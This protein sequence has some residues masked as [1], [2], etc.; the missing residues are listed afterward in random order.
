VARTRAQ[1]RRRTLLITLALVVTLIVL[2]FARDVSRAAHGAITARRSE[3]RSFGALANAL[4]LEENSF[5]GRL[6]RLLSQGGTL[7]REV[8][9]ARLNQLDEQLPNWIT[10]SDQLRRPVLS[11]NVNDELNLL[12]QE[13]VAAYQVLLGQ[14]A[15]ELEL[16]WTPSTVS[17]PTSIVNPAASLIATSQQWNVDRF[18][19][20]KEP[21]T[22]R[23]HATSALSAQYFD[24]NGAQALM[25]SAS[26]ALMRAVDIAAIRVSP[27]PLPSAHTDLLLPPVTSVQIGVTVVNDGYDDQPVTLTVQVILLN[28][29]GR[30]FSQRMTTTLGPMAAYA[31]VP[32]ILTTAASERAKVQIHV[33]GAHAPLGKSTIEDF[34]L[35]M[36]PSGNPAPG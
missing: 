31:F 4:I 23:L 12:T 25:R 30:A 33:I 11:H 36:S 32:R 10:T 16:P 5:D 2:V 9:A 21:G 6:D 24:H 22:V 35:E 1:R 20:V 13:R 26:L 17:S 34:V 7:S 14:V 27:A 3:N 19:L 8:F 28:H 18:A 29:L 15:H